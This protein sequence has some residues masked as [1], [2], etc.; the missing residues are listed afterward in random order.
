M[1]QQQ[2]Q[3]L[4]FFESAN[5]QTDFTVARFLANGAAGPVVP[6]FWRRA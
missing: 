2:D 3:N 1:P 5:S 6:Y 4:A